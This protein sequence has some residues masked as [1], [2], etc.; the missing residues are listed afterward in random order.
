[1]CVKFTDFYASRKSADKRFLTK[2]SCNPIPAIPLTVVCH[3]LDILPC[4][5]LREMVYIRKISN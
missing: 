5:V 3:K 1:M 2:M 4:G